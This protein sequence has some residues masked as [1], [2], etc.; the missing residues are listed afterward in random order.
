MTGRRRGS[1]S[2]RSGAPI[3]GVKREEFA[4]RDFFLYPSPMEEI[5]KGIPGGYEK[6]SHEETDRDA[7]ATI[8]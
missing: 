1:I 8:A 7:G 2:G 6:T 4:S 3:E 5:R